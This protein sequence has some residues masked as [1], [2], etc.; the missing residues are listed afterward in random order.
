MAF[1]QT[2]INYYIFDRIEKDELGC[3]WGYKGNKFCEV[4]PVSADDTE[5]EL[6][7][8]GFAKCD[9]P[10]STETFCT[11]ESNVKCNEDGSWELY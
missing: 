4:F 1:N 11:E 6:I 8:N 3:H 5:A 7:Q 9:A 10:D 2:A